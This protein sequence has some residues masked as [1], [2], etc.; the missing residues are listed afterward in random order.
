M[1][2]WTTGLYL[3]KKLPKIRKLEMKF[4]REFVLLFFLSHFTK[5]VQ[6][7]TTESVGNF[8]CLCVQSLE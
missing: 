4:V 5:A 8:L 1:S 3:S 7:A 6:S 2:R